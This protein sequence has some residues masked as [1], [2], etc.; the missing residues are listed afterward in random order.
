[1]RPWRE[2]N[3]RISAAILVSMR[4]RSIMEEPPAMFPRSHFY[5]IFSFSLSKMA[6][7]SPRGKI[8]KMVGDL[9]RKAGKKKE[10]KEEEHFFH[11]QRLARWSQGSIVAPLH[12]HPRGVPPSI[13]SADENGSQFDV[14]SSNIKMKA[15]PPSNG[16]TGASAGST[17]SAGSAGSAG[18]QSTGSGWETSRFQSIFD[19]GVENG[20]K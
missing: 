2:K 17:G 19:A 18:S 4:M 10:K 14:E 8:G 5:W 12:C 20:N 9:I 13:P 11:L 16:A 1:M 3:D 6:A 15:M 7:A